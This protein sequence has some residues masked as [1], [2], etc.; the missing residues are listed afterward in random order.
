MAKAVDIWKPLVPNWC[1]A[2]TP[3]WEC[4]L[5][6]QLF[7]PKPW[8]FFALQVI[9]QAIL[10][11]HNATTPSEIVALAKAVKNTTEQATSSFVSNCRASDSNAAVTQS[12]FFFANKNLQ[13]DAAVRHVTPRFRQ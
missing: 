7:A 3:L 11:R 2:G 12:F 8:S 1:K 6:D 5:G 4:L 10:A 9:T 13:E